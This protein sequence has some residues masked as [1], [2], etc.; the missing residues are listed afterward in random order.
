MRRLLLIPLVLV[1]GFSAI[2]RA[3]PTAWR[4][5][6]SQPE[7]DKEPEAI[8]KARDLGRHGPKAAKSVPAL[9]EM[10]ADRDDRIRLAAAE[11]LWR[12]EHKAD[13]LLPHYLE[14]LTATTPEVRAA[15]AWR[16]GRLGDDSRAVVLVLA[17]ALR[18][19]DYE[20]RV[21]AGLALAN[22]GPPAAVALPALVRVLSDARLDDPDQRRSG[23]HHVESSPAL[24]ALVELTDEAIP[25]LIAS[26]HFKRRPISSISDLSVPTDPEATRRTALAFAAF[27][28]R[29]VALLVKAIQ[30]DD[31][32][33]RGGA[34]EALREV[35][36]NGVK[37][38]ES[39][40]VELEKRLDDAEASVRHSAAR[41]MAV[42]RPASTNAAAI[43]AEKKDLSGDEH[44]DRIA[45]MGRMCPHNKVAR[46][47][48]FQQLADKDEKTAIAVAD[49]LDRL[50]SPTEPEI[51]AWSVLLAHANKELRS[52]AIGAL[53]FHGPAAKAAL[54]DVRARLA[55]STDEYEQDYLFDAILRIDPDD[56]NRLEFLER[57]LA[58]GMSP[59]RRTAVNHLAELGPAAKKAF[60]T[61]VAQLFTR[62]AKGD[63]G[64]F[65]NDDAKARVDALARISPRS[66][67]LIAIL[68]RALR[69][70]YLRSLVGSKNSWYMRDVLED[71]LLA[72]L[73]AAAPDLRHA[74]ADNDPEVRQ[75]VA[76]VCLRRGVD[77]EEAVRVLTDNP[78]YQL[79]SSNGTGRFQER[80]VEMLVHRPAGVSPTTAAKMLWKAWRTADA[81]AREALTRGLVVF[82]REALPILL[83][84][85]RESTSR[86]TRLDLAYLLAKF[87]GQAKHVVPDL[88]EELRAVG[89]ARPYRAMATLTTLGPDAADAI[90]DLVPLLTHSHAGVRALAART[91]G[92]IGRPARPV[93]TELKRMLN[94]P[95]N[96]VRLL[97]A[98]ALSQVDPGVVE[99]L[100]VLWGILKIEH[101]RFG[102]DWPE[103]KTPQGVARDRI[104]ISTADVHEGILRL[105]EPAVQFL[106][107]VLDDTGLDEWSAANISAQC[108][109]DQRIQAAL[110]LARLGPEAKSALP[111]LVRA[112]KDR[113]TFVRDAAASALGRMGSAAKD[114][115]PEVI[116]LLEKQ[117]RVVAV[118]GPWAGGAST[119][120]RAFDFRAAGRNRLVRPDDFSYGGYRR[121]PF[122]R[123]RSEYPHDPAFVLS[124]IDAEAR[125][126]QPLLAEMAKDPAHPGRLAAA[127]ALWRSGCPSPDLDAAFAAGLDA[128]AVAARDTRA[129]MTSDLRLAL[130]EPGGLT[131]SSAPALVRWLTAADWWAD[132]DDVVAVADALA[133]LG[134]AAR[135]HASALQSLGGDEDGQSGKKMAVALACVR[136]AEAKPGHSA[137]FR[138]TLLAID[139]RSFFDSISGASTARVLAARGL[140]VLAERGDP[141]ARALLAEVAKGDESLHVRLS[142]LESLGQ[143]KETA[144]D[145]RSGLE[146][147]LRNADS[148]VRVAAITALGRMGL[149]DESSRNALKAA[150]QDPILGVRQTAKQAMAGG[151]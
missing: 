3:Q 100:D 124:R 126:A 45:D 118:G 142:A 110:L 15:S 31:A 103:I 144:A 55:K 137:L 74:L 67:E 2:S 143:I 76:L 27:G 132:G 138:E 125:S 70:R 149:S 56:P 111:A 141:R 59:T 44:K 28:S 135:E 48:L 68:L 83:A 84:Q 105:G 148:D 16:L 35:A 99:V 150:K 64:A 86:Q 81:E 71:H 94:D 1:I 25:H 104:R 78:W 130:T 106:A 30:S 72:C 96:A 21:Q 79:V 112:L 41:V 139:R 8:R 122:A 66:E 69:D 19:E 89:A 133:N 95:D 114:A 46:E 26:F 39:V 97:A 91:L 42:V 18:D 36:E 82:Q 129:P 34:A 4:D 90:P 140:G 128:H 6:S 115:T 92:T 134:S 23:S 93:G 9:K 102:R 33:T 131:K 57:W 147:L 113:D 49:L 119:A 17:G 73:P 98:E 87:E 22:I 109:S 145:A 116:A 50:P 47:W 107:A 65:A 117:N 24:P 20:V 58:E 123:F 37:L 29:G 38:P 12:I 121:D 151:R 62:P 85:L 13:D 10:L 32:P 7:Q 146:A 136:L 60:P 5:S 63:R 54:P 80:V 40:V 14:L 120:G 88:R 127:L 52:H 101:D 75:S 43:L 11:A 53:S 51:K 77:V 61:I 108:G